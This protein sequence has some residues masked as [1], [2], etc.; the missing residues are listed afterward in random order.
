M[1]LLHSVLRD[2][3]AVENIQP[4]E[5]LES[6]EMVD[7]RISDRLAIVQFDD[8]KVFLRR[9]TGADVTHAFIGDL[10]ASGESLQRDN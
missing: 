3:L 2:L 6:K 10:F 8:A 5:I 9:S 1:N 4:L 7:G